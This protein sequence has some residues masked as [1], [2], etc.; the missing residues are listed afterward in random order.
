MA[1]MAVTAVAAALGSAC[2]FAVSTSLQ[3]RAATAAPASAAR[4]GGLFRFLLRRP[5]WHLGLLVGAFAFLL[6]AVAV[7]HGALAVVQPIVV[8]G[9]VLAMPVRAA[10]DRRTSARGELAWAAVTAVGL[11]SFVVA[12]NPA[13]P[14]GGPTGSHAALFI[15]AGAIA[16]TMCVRSGFKTTSDLR[17]G[18]LLGSAAGLLFGLV[19]GILKMVVL[20]ALGFWTFVLIGA[21]ILLGGWGVALNQRAYQVSPLSV[22][23][24]VLN[25]VDVVV[26]IAF[27]FYVFGE[28]PGHQ[29]LEMLAES[30][31]LVLMGF[32]VRRL[33]R[34]AEEV[35]PTSGADAL[36]AET[37]DV[38][39][40]V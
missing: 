29:P 32:G 23:M 8:S 5:G 20:D 33:A 10:L 7:K 24:P 17:R 11:A 28:T 1:E 16:A 4:A 38:G 27:G 40:G 9:V 36:P 6:H 12:S 15:L 30:L 3:H 39:P 37:V 22:S 31:G 19:A 21:L 14:S 25:I 13:T 34:D 35:V 18:A 2:A 26:A